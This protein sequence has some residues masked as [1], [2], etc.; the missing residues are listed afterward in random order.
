[1]LAYQVN[2]FCFMHEITLRQMQTTVTAD[3]Y[4]LVALVS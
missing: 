1:M 2:S 4:K 3:F